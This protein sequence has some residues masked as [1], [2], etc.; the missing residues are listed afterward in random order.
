MGFD[1]KDKPATAVFVKGLV[2]MLV[3]NFLMA[4]VLAHNNA[5]WQFVPGIKELG[6]TG[7]AIN[8]A[9]FTW[10]GFYFPGELG[11]TV[12]EKKSWKLFFINS[13][14]HLLSLA[15]VSFILTFWTK[16]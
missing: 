14:Y 7:S 6:M 8:A 3:G 13:G 5:A 9:V 12:W 16:H 15:I 4:W 2:F 1:P 11:A 10:L